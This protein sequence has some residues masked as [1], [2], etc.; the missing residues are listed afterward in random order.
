[1]SILE[2]IQKRQIQ[3]R[4]WTCSSLRWHSTC[5]NLFENVFEEFMREN[6]YSFLTCSMEKA[7]CLDTLQQFCRCLSFSKSK[8]LKCMNSC[9]EEKE[10]AKF[11]NQNQK[12]RINSEAKIFQYTIL[13]NNLFY[14]KFKFK[15]SIAL[16]K[17]KEFLLVLN[18]DIIPQQK[19]RIDKF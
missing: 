15:C 4:V 8:A 9:V 5:V 18:F 2:V 17:F 6:E 16:Y 12:Q 3:D 10:T 1:M 13:A 19:Q 7:I 14:L 11:V